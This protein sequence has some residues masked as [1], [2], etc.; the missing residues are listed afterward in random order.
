[1]HAK[2]LKL[3][4]QYKKGEIKK[5]KYLAEL[6]K[7]VDDKEITQE[8]ADDAE[9]FDPE[10]DKPIFTQADVDGMIARRTNQAIRKILKDAGVEVDATNKDLPGKVVD[11]VKVGA[12]KAEAAKGQDPEGLSKATARITSMT[13]DVKTLRQENAILKVISKYKPVSPSAVTSLLKSDY[14]HMIDYL[15]EETG[16]IDLKTVDKAFRKMQIDE[17]TLFT[18]EDQQEKPGSKGGSGFQ[19]KGPGGAG[20]AG[21]G[22]GKDIDTKVAEALAMMGHARKETTK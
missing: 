12:G 20:A 4:E 19:G 2:I 17:P 8:D 6:A 14:A 11:L 1:M 22:S 9:D 13:A 7:L 15:D 3:Q 21:T 16:E 18:A 5:S 10:E